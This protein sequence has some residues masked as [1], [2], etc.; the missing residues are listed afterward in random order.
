[1]R[2]RVF[3][4]L[5]VVLTLFATLSACEVTPENIEMWKGTQNGPEKIAA[6][7]VNEKLVV[8]IRAQAAVALVQIGRWPIL[9][10]AFEYMND[11]EKSKVSDAMV[12]LLKNMLDDV[13][14]PGVPKKSQVDAKDALMFIY[15][16]TTA[17][18][19]PEVEQL[20]IGWVVGDFNS[21]FITGQNG[22]KKI[23]ATIG[24]PAYKAVAE[25]VKGDLPY[26]EPVCQ[27]LKEGNNKEALALA[28]SNLAESFMKSGPNSTELQ[29]K[30]AAILGGEPLQKQ[31]LGMAGNTELPS[32]VQRFAL[33][34]Y[35]LNPN[36]ADINT[37]FAIASN[38]KFDRFHREETYYAIAALKQKET[39][40]RLMELMK[41]KDP[42]YR[43]VGFRVCLQVGGAEKLLE[44][45]T[46]TSK[47]NVKWTTDDLNEFVIKRIVLYR[48]EFLKPML[49]VL[50]KALGDPSPFVRA[51]AVYVLSHK[52]DKQDIEKLKPLSND[53]GR[54]QGFPRSTVGDAAKDAVKALEKKP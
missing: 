22:I 35:A 28:S 5:A 24:T 49:E 40:P 19:K 20:L 17:A 12:P 1:M 25:M 34:A 26:L 33:R 23:V 37:L 7:V 39:L 42:F 41:S 45:L 27:L 10:K 51:V 6:A 48:P 13:S 4:N 16:T 2:D 29:F 53:R 54:I 31:L 3:R 9:E 50:R 38:E 47:Q 32:S 14:R 44:I 18:E 15:P 46:Y 11:A 43:G 8:N 52:G 21:R 36:P 30:A